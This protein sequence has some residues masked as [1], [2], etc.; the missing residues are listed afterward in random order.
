METHSDHA[1][2]FLAVQRKYAATQAV[3]S[4]LFLEVCYNEVTTE[5]LRS[6]DGYRTWHGRKPNYL[7]PR[8]GSPLELALLARPR[9]RACT[10]TRIRRLL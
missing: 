3:I 10:L 6:A 9:T 7:F 8:S 4:A 1:F 2:T 5:P